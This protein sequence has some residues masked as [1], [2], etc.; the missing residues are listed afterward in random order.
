MDGLD[1]ELPAALRRA[2]AT[3]EMR[4][5]AGVLA[6]LPSLLR[7]ALP[8]SAYVVIADENTWIAAGRQVTALLASA[9]LATAEPMILRETPRVQPRAATARALAATLGAGTA[10]PVAAG[11]G[12]ISDLVKYAAALADRPYACVPTAASMDGY[13]ASGAALRDDGF[14]RTFACPAPAVVVADLDIVATAPAGMAAWGYGD[15]A[16][17]LVAGADWVLAD[18]LGEDELNPGPFALVQDNLAAWL[19]EPAA[20]RRGERAALDGLTR[21]LLM[22]GLAMQAHGNSR[23]ASGS[24]HQFAHLWEMEA[25]AVDGVPVSHGACVGVGCLSMLAA[26]AW[27]L[28]QDVPGI[29]PSDLAARL[30][31]PAA[32]RAEIAAAF[33]KPFM[34]RNAETEALA[35][36]GD[37]AATERRLRTLRQAWPD[38]APRLRQMLPPAEDMQQRLRAVGAPACAADIGIPAETHAADYR[39]ARLIRRRYTGLDLLHE[40]GW[41][42]DAVRGLFDSKGFWG[43]R[44]PAPGEASEEFS[45][46]AREG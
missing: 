4:V 36:T 13:A 27:L 10:V 39:R 7:Q 2:V 6:A 41:L 46:R 14:K 40:L 16:G 30:P 18:A 29:A 9:G 12:V 32:V 15:L 1:H 44:T 23:P 3:R 37:V 33:D 11:A 22:S 34:A 25:I 31:T 8:A 42:D 21:G 28:R 17:K 19:K 24:D 43:R 5:G 38:L 20:I 45:F 35:K 26:Y